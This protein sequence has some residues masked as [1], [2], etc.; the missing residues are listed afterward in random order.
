MLTLP[1]LACL[2]AAPPADPP[3]TPREIAFPDDRA[4]GTVYTRPVAEGEER[5]SVYGDSWQR[6]GEARGDVAVSVGHEVRLDVA[7]A[8]HDD[9][10]FFAA[11]RPEDLHAVR[12]GDAEIEDDQLRHLAHLTGLQ[13]LDLESATLT[14]AAAPHLGKLT[15]LRKV[16][17][18]A[19]GVERHGFGVGDD[20]ARAL[21]ALPHL[22]WLDARL[23]KI[24]DAGAA[25]LAGSDSLRSLTL[26]GTPVTDAGLAELGT[27]EHLEDLRLGVYD[28]GADVTDAGLVHLAGMKRLRSLGL[29]GTKITDDGL[30]HL[31]PLTTLE[32]LDLDNTGVTEAGLVHLR[33]LHRLERLRIDSVDTDAGAEALA[34]LTSL[35]SIRGANLHITEAGVAALV[36]LPHL[37]RLSLADGG[38]T[39]ACLEHVS[40]MSSLKIFWLQSCPVTDAGVA[41][42]AGLTNLEHLMLKRTRVSGGGLAPLADLP[43]LRGLSLSFG[44]RSRDYFGERPTLAGVGKLRA[45]E[46]LSLD[47]WGLHPDD[48]RDLGGLPKLETLTVRDIPVDDTAAHH[49]A[50]IPS[51]TFLNI[52]EAAVSDVG[53]GFLANLRDLEH[54]RIRGAFTAAGLRELA[55]LP[56]LR[57]LFVSSPYLTDA[58]LEELVASAPNLTDVSLG[59][60]RVKTGL[61][62]ARSYRPDPLHPDRAGFR[63]DHDGEEWAALA[64]LENGPPPALTVTDWL[65]TGDT[66]RTLDDFAGRVVLVDFWGTWCGPCRAAMPQLRALHGEYADAGLTIVGVHSTTGASNMAD[67]VAEEGLPWLFAADVDRATADAWRVPAWPT[68]FLIDRAGRLRFA[69]LHAD[70][71]PRAV[72]L[73][74]AEGP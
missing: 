59:E 74:I 54:L 40:R 60:Y 15:G 65:H 47:G 2:L 53:L 51:L 34:E 10:A 44:E 11:L 71:L 31:A 52:Q 27:M 56:R 28:E 70:D 17:L 50:A 25:A 39:D 49:L 66:P 1:L 32:V 3:A 4:V 73:L 67:Y 64:P 9:L 8:A 42:L 33:P 63:R 68:V 62:R 6:V 37:E 57:H 41:R 14:D 5:L 45:L 35:R 29:A 69:D 26:A 16:D 19:F 18:E 13:L 46:Y 48:F 7:A 36:R 38:I 58:D 43:N 55:T 22:E 30:R 21:A 12:L 72:G 23:T 20:T 61:F 24:G